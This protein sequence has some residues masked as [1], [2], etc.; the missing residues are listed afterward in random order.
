MPGQCIDLIGGFAQ[1]SPGPVDAAFVRGVVGERA[2][3]QSRTGRHRD[4]HAGPG[5][6]RIAA[7]LAGHAGEDRAVL[8]VAR[9]IEIGLVGKADVVGAFAAKQ[10][11]ARE[12][13]VEAAVALHVG[14]QVGLTLAAGKQSDV[15]TNAETVLI[16][17][18]KR[19]FEL[20]LLRRHIDEAVVTGGRRFQRIE[21]GMAGGRRH[22]VGQ[23]DTQVR[24]AAED[25]VV[26]GQAGLAVV[27]AQR[28]ELLRV[29]SKQIGRAVEPERRFA[30]ALQTQAPDLFAIADRQRDLIELPIGT[31][32]L[33]RQ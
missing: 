9:I 5:V 16:D 28:F 25:F 29:L 27:F 7:H 22:H 23:G 3:D 26:Q 17:M 10:P 8:F 32:R 15:L 1:Q 14:T 21:G 19:I 2:V 11:G 4:A 6:G 18:A 33:Q 12:P 24:R 31:I 13:G 30:A 20:R